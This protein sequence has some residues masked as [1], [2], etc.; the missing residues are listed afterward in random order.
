MNFIEELPNGPL[1]VYRKRASFNWKLLKLNLEGEDCIISQAKLWKFIKSNPEFQHANESLSLNATRRRCY[2]QLNALSKIEGDIFD[3]WSHWLRLYDPSIGPL[4]RIGQ[5]TIAEGILDLGTE[6]HRELAQKFFDVRF[7]GCLGFTEIAHG[8]NLKGLQTTAIYNPQTESFILNSPNFKAAKCWSG[9]LGKMATHTLL[10]AQLITPDN[11][12]HD[13]HPFIVPIRDPET[14]LPLPN[15]II[16]DLGEKIGLNGVDNG[17][18]MFKNYSLPRRNLLNRNAD[19]SKDGKYI[20]IMENRSQYFGTFLSPLATGRMGVTIHSTMFSR[21]ALTIA[22]RYCACRKQ[23]GPPGKEEWPVIEYQQTRIFPHLAALYAWTIFGYNLLR[24]KEA[25]SKKLKDQK[26]LIAK[27]L[28]IH[29]LLSAVKPLSTW[30]TQQIIQDCRESCAGHGYL[31][32]SRFGEIRDANDAAITYE[33]ENTVL[34][35]QASQWLL[36][37]YDNFQNGKAIASPFE[38]AKFI[39]NSE[40]ILSL[41]FNLSTVED[42]FK[43]DHLLLMLK[44]LICYYLKKTYIHVK[45]MKINGSNSFEVRNNSQTYFARPLSLV[46][47]EH[48]VVETFITRIEDRVFGDSERKVLTKLCA[49]F[50]ACSLEKRLD[51]FYVGG[52]ASENSKLQFLIRDGIISISQDLVN[53]A[54]ALIDVLA[55]PDFVVNSPLG[56]SDGKIYKHLEDILFK[57]PKNFEPPSWWKEIRSNL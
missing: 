11:V 34:I 31:K 2:R 35:Q 10:Y 27:N 14:H 54:V 29:A 47:A 28:E 49:L 36:K 18:L 37:Q 15:V 32:A 38:T 30:T 1:D 57:D 17:F 56:M 12:N 20:A 40:Y 43:L 9:L 53:E 26:N 13:L 19:V 46:Y 39:P 7:I 23:F 45:K 42:T 3:A 41:K 4:R 16:G 22:I 51:D 48:A 55:P 25:E 21:L 33:G 8:S 5:S 52:Y 44:W 6:R 24:M 50:A